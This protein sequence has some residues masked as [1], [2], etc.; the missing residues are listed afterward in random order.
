MSSPAEA[1]PLERPAAPSTTMSVLVALSVSHLLND[2]IQSLL[3]AIYPVLKD[4]FQLTY[5]DIGLITLT[6]QMVASI[7]QP[8]VGLYTDKHPK[9][10]SLAM[11]MGCSLAGLLLLSR[12]HNLPTILTAAVMVGL[13]SAVFHPEASRLARMASG[14]RHGFAQALFQLGG[15][16]GTSLGP[17]LAAIVIVPAGQKSIAWFSA[18]ALAAMAILTRVG[19]WYREKLEQAKKRTA[20]AHETSFPIPGR[21]VLLALLVLVLLVISKYIYLSSLTN[22]YTFF[23]IHKFG[24]SVQNAQFCLFAF[25]F[26]VAV[27][28]IAGGPIGDRFGRRVVIWFSILG[29]APFSLALPYVSLPW[30]IVLSMCA[31]AILASAFSA[32]LVFAQELMPGKV[33]MVAG[34][35]FGLAFGVGGISA[36]S[37]GELADYRGIEYVFHLCAFLPLTGLIAGLLPKIER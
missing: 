31:G 17:A 14:G 1:L 37:L 24:V 20:S 25:L 34:L 19:H 5:G 28:T 21:K 10:Y 26:S 8:L 11:G 3:P 23:L 22:Y 7:L 16:F 30:T 9:P 35:F 12:A 13:G 36:A 4:L 33:G 2:T 27:G 6:T 15:N 18:V 29:V 32:I